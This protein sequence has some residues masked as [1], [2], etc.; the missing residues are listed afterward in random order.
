MQICPIAA[1]TVYQ[2]RVHLAR[3][4]FREL[5]NRWNYH[6]DERFYSVKKH[7]RLS[8]IIAP[9]ITKQNVVISY[10]ADVSLVYAS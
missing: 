9:A 8:F 2:S 1:T 5:R 4:R 7:E 10:F 6:Y 3:L